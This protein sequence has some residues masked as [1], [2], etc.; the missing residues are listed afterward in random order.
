MIFFSKGKQFGL[1]IAFA[2]VFFMAGCN[3]LDPSI[4][5]EDNVKVLV[6]TELPDLSGVVELT[7]A[8]LEDVEI[9]YSNVNMDTVGI[10]IVT[11]TINSDSENPIAFELNLEVV[12]YPLDNTPLIYGVEDITFVIGEDIPNLLAGVT[13]IDREYGDL[14]SLVTI[15]AVDVDFTTVGSYEV[16]YYVS[17]IDGYSQSEKAMLNVIL[18]D[19]DY[20][21]PS[22][23]VIVEQELYGVVDVQG[24]EVVPME[25]AS[26]TYMGEGML[27]LTKPTD[28]PDVYTRMSL[29]EP[30]GYYYNLNTNE[31]VDYDYRLYGDFNEG[32]VVVRNNEGM[33]SYMN[34]SGEVVLPFI[35]SEAYPFI[36]GRAIVKQ[37]SNYGLISADGTEYLGI[38]Y[39]Y[40][41]RTFDGNY[42][43]EESDG[44]YV[45]SDEMSVYISTFSNRLFTA[46]VTSDG[47][48][49][50]IVEQQGK[51]GLMNEEYEMVLDAKY[52]HIYQGRLNTF[53]ATKNSGE[54]DFYGYT[55][56]SLL[57]NIM[58]YHFIG[59][60][61]EVLLSTGWGLY[62]VD[63]Q[64]IS[65]LAIYDDLNLYGDSGELYIATNQDGLK[66]ILTRGNFQHMMFVN[67]DIT[68]DED[69]GYGTYTLEDETQGLIGE[70]GY[71]FT[72]ETYLKIGDF[73][74]G[75][76][77]VENPI[78]GLQGY[79]D[80][81]GH[82]AIDLDYYYAGD[83][84]NGYAKVK[85]SEDVL[86]WN[87]IDTD[88]NLVSDVLYQ[89]VNPFTDFGYSEVIKNDLYTVINTSGDEVVP[90]TSRLLMENDV[91]ILHRDV[92][93]GLYGAYY[94]NGDVLFPA[95]YKDIDYLGDN[96]FLITH[97]NY[98]S[99]LVDIDGNLLVNAY[100]QTQNHQFVNGLIVGGAY[101]STVFDKLGNIIF[102][103]NPSDQ[104]IDESNGVFQ[105][106][107][108]YESKWGLLDR[109]GN[110]VVTPKYLSMLP[111]EFGMA[112][113]LDPDTLLWGF[114]DNKGEYVI[115]P[116]YYSLN[117]FEED[118]PFAIVNFSSY[119]QGLIDEYGRVVVEN[120]VSVTPITDGFEVYQY[121]EIYYLYYIDDVLT[122]ELYDED[123]D[124]Q[125]TMKYINGWGLYEYG[126]LVI[127]HEYQSI[128]YDTLLNG[129]VV[130]KRGQKGLYNVDFELITPIY[131][132][133]MIYVNSQDGHIQV[134][135]NGNY[136][137][138]GMDGT[139]LI[140]PKY[141]NILYNQATDSFLVMNGGVYGLYD[142]AGTMILD[143]EYNSLHFVK[144]E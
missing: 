87:F 19:G 16:T 60:D 24:N 108:Y 62:R 121:G 90:Y 52:T 109:N 74:E 133:E 115:E 5:G 67:V 131:F 126:T 85:L 111:F 44:E 78:T 112:A 64:A 29:P 88:G 34:A 40:V 106:R 43:R 20:D 134:T 28:E 22:N 132:D 11:Y 83:F 6:G 86:S 76:C 110:D 42:I 135:K 120:A 56:D 49:L 21:I 66:G 99:Y 58:N 14:S 33:Y 63:T 141:D 54:S 84:N 125:Y 23:F 97:T 117:A 7:D 89:S 103:V 27:Y 94:Y 30:D 118:E 68:Y 70:D 96:M 15:D 139:E 1:I 25:Y 93:T 100:S 138:Y 46:T 65:I 61:I 81:T 104:L 113:V 144:E 51:I 79:I 123:G 119:N 77:M 128:E 114:I 72:Y 92:A 53:I 55:N 127:P 50:Y 71:Q 9:D 17:N 13:A 69:S 122:R 12:D 137:L 73:S 95:N 142:S 124:V 129:F 105:Y 107:S 2:L 101:S 4:T 35:Y 48:I 136:G 10:Y 57:E 98:T 26:I 47:T 18:D 38:Q 75:F 143:V 45:V 41:G 80:E 130:N 140:Y 116:Q 37:W 31:F 8:A 91:F 59:K 102:Q 39:P 36:D 32:L 3:E 82:E